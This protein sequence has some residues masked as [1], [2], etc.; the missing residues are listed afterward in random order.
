MR[1]YRIERKQ[2]LRQTLS[3]LGA[4]SVAGF[5]WNSLYTRMVYTAATR[6]LATLEILVHLD[7]EDIPTDR[8]FVEIDIPDALAILTINQS[9]LP[10]NWDAVPPQPKTQHLGDVFVADQKAAVLQVPSVL[11]PQEFNYLINPL[12]PEAKK[13]KI[14]SRV[15]FRFDQRLGRKI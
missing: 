7:M 9:A 14:V 2:Y 5:R 12:H 10:R 4:A 3:G 13:I 6:S 11:V 8:Y 1:V 15:P